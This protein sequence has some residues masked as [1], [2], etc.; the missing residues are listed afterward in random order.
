MKGENMNKPTITDMKVDRKFTEEWDGS[1]FINLD[2][3]PE[4]VGCIISHKKNMVEYIEG[5]HDLIDE[6]IGINN[7]CD[8]CLKSNC[9]SDHK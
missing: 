3:L 5:L 7:L 8:N 2:K 6:I 1:G 9:N 4:M